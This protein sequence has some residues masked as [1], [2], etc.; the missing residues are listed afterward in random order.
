M[1][2]LMSFYEDREEEGG[3]DVE[4]KKKKQRTYFCPRV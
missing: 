1:K 4:L 2:I 3:E